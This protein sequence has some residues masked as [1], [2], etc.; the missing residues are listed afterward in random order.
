MPHRIKLKASYNHLQRLYLMALL[1]DNSN[2]QPK[3]IG[4]FD[5]PLIQIC[6]THANKYNK[7]FDQ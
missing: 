7:G 3:C 5:I 1:P 4:G 6:H 2:H